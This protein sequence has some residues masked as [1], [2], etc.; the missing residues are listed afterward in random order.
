MDNDKCA[1]V[2]CPQEETL[3]HLLWTYPFAEQCGDL[4]CPTRQPN[5]SIMEAFVD[6]RLKLQVPFNMEI[7]ILAAWDIWITRNNHIFTNINPSINRW[8]ETS[9]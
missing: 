3:E 2:K 8:K 1:M 7:I 4:I 6:L 9:M 5:L